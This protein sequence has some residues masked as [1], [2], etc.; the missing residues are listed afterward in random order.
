MAPDVRVCKYDTL[1]QGWHTFITV[2]LI[3]YSADYQSHV[4]I[5]TH[6]NNQCFIWLLLLLFLQF[7]VFFFSSY[8]LGHR[9]SRIP[10]SEPVTGHR[11]AAGRGGA[12]RPH[13][14]NRASWRHQRYGHTNVKMFITSLKSSLFDLSLCVL[15]KI[16]GVI[17]VWVRPRA[18]YP[19][20]LWPLGLC[21]HFI[22][23][24]ELKS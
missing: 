15:W 7:Y 23:R 21:S 24:E 11:A 9:C 8:R 14:S 18:L 6:W 2:S 1:T 10:G 16:V 22:V 5:N 17:S 3:S 20:D 12:A 19:I 13:A 4:R